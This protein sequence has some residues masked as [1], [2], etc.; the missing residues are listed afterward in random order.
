MRHPLVQQLFLWLPLKL[1]LFIAALTR[2]QSQKAGSRQN[3]NIMDVNIQEVINLTERYDIDW[4]IHGHTH[5]PA[6]HEIKR[7]THTIHRAVLGAWDD[8]TGS[9]IKV[10]TG[11]VELIQFSY[12]EPTQFNEVI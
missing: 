4:V 9:M 12:D 8:T 3:E 6:I 10:S 11:T 7:H 1:R 2:Q 5:R